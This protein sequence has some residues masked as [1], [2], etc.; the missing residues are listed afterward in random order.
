MRVPLI[1]L[2]L[3]RVHMAATAF[4][5]AAACPFRSLS[6]LFFFFAGTLSSL[7]IEDDTRDP[8]VSDPQASKTSL[9]WSVS[10]ST[11]GKAKGGFLLG[12]CQ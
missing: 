8:A 4:A 5:S 1:P 10:R 7:F 2:V 3:W 12:G 6:S 9:L 11:L